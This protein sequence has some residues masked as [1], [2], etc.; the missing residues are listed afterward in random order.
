MDSSAGWNDIVGHLV[1]KPIENF[2]ALLLLGS[3]SDLA[4]LRAYYLKILTLKSV[5]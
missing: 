1:I 5:S 2:I 3:Y 4:F